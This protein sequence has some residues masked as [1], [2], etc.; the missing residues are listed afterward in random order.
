VEQF[1]LDFVPRKV[2]LSLGDM[3]ELPA[4]VRAWV[5]F[6]LGRRGLEERWIAETEA[7]VD[8]FARAFLERATD[9]ASF[10]PAKGIFD[11]MLASGLDM[12]DPAAIQ[13]WIHEYNERL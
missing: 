11:E 12:D 10:G 5:R 9:P 1:L 13:K 8:T 3:R 2:S 7:A 4:V 6:A